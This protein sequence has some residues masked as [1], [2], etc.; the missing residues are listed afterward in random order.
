[1]TARL[2]RHADVLVLVLVVI[3][4]NGTGL[5]WLAHETRASDAARARQARTE[6]AAQRRAGQVIERKLCRTLDRLGA[7]EPPPGNP[8]TNPSRAYEQQQH[9]I[10]AQLAPD[11]GCPRQEGS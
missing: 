4:I 11:V 2:R 9:V 6:Q 7:N 1:L 10:F 3:L 5:F 8:D